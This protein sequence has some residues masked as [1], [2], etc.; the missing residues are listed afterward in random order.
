MKKPD[1]S[2][3]VV[4]ALITDVTEG[5]AN[6]IELVFEF[7][8]DIRTPPGEIKPKLAAYKPKYY[9]FGERAIIDI[10][11]FAIIGVGATNYNK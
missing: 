7:Y 2:R 9:M 11:S 4:D 3:I 5:N 6:A 8:P 1:W 10:L